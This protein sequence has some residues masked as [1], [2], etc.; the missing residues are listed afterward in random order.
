[1]LFLG[2]ITKGSYSDSVDEFVI[3][4]RIRNLHPPRDKGHS[5]DHFAKL[6]ITHTPFALLAAMV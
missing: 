6:S 1:M 4:T 3:T 5:R 2:G